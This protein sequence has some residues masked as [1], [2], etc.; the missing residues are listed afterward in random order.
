MVKYRKDQ[1]YL[2]DKTQRPSNEFKEQENYVY[3][4]IER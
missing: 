4:S 2:I 3:L 1:R